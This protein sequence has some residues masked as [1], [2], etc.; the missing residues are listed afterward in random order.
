M[1]RSINLVNCQ[2]IE[3]VTYNLA[4]DRV[5]VIVADNNVG[6]SILFKMLQFFASD[7]HYTPAE[8]KELIRW[9]ADYA[10]ISI[11]LDTDEI[12]SVGVFPTY[13]TYLYQRDA[14]SELEQRERFTSEELKR[15]GLLTND[16]FIANVLDGD[17]DMAL[18]SSKQRTNYQLIELL[19]HDETIENLQAKVSTELSNLGVFEQELVK[20][21]VAIDS[22]LSASTYQ[23]L[24]A[25]KEAKKYVE[26]LTSLLE[27][28][29]GIS[30]A[31]DNFL[32]SDGFKYNDSAYSLLNKLLLPEVNILSSVDIDKHLGLLSKL[33]FPYIDTSDEVDLQKHLKLLDTLLLPK[34]DCETEYANAVTEAFNELQLKSDV[35]EC[36]LHG[37]VVSMYDKCLYL[38]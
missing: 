17:Q 26:A 35:F 38:D 33:D 7:K 10:L 3:N 15:I 36:P 2:S 8:R 13:V 18:V 28:L 37:K 4:T 12:F 22:L 32:Y 30:D 31:L 25:L 6:K 27:K 20:K 24:D 14:N 9:G 21:R 29:I 11:T 34:I 19:F 16:D 23:N 5:N 1:I